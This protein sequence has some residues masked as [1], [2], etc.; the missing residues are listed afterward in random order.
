M[1]VDGPPVL[2]T[3]GKVEQRNAVA[4]GGEVWAVV[5]TAS[6]ASMVEAGQGQTVAMPAIE[7]SRPMSV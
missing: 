1:V 3:V 6:P 5:M 7:A 2:H 4:V